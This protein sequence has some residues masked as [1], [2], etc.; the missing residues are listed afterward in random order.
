MNDQRDIQLSPAG[1]ARRDAMLGE[2]IGTMRRVHRRRRTRRAALATACMI[3][4]SGSLTALVLLSQSP[5]QQGERL[6]EGP[7]PSAVFAMVSTDPGVLQR[8][9]A[10]PTSAVQLIDDDALLAEL[11]A[12]DRPTGLVRSGGRVWLTENVV[13]SDAEDPPP[14]P[15][16]P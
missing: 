6:V 10:R 1:E 12:I 4:L 9:G 14:A 13:D 5:P 11:T 16:T 7:R 8:Y 3:A 15:P 2:L